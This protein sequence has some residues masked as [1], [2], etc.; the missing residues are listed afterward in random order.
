MCVCL[1]LSVR[2]G[3]GITVEKGIKSG[4]LTGLCCFGEFPENHFEQSAE[5]SVSVLSYP[6]MVFYNQ[7][8]FFF[9]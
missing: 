4:V 8:H 7:D 3:A 1:R 9:F 6:V 5:S 2:V